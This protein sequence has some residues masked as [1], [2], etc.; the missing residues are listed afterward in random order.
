MT[1]PAQN[2]SMRTARPTKPTK[3]T[4]QEHK[5]SKRTEVRIRRA[6]TGAGLKWTE[7]RN[8]ETNHKTQGL[9]CHAQ[10]IP[11]TGPLPNPQ[12]PKIHALPCKGGKAFGLC[13]VV[14]GGCRG[15]AIRGTGGT[16]KLSWGS[17]KAATYGRQKQSNQARQ[18]NRR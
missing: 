15:F 13:G 5:R 10:H 6:S 1:C 4:K 11:C 14:L 2:T 9:Q 3:S 17:L 18:A 8:T 16:N 7:A 12:P